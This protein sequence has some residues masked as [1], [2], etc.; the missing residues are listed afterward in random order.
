MDAVPTPSAEPATSA[1]LPATVVTTP[2]GVTRRT[3][4]LDPSATNTFP[5]AST[6]RA[7]ALGM[8]SSAEVPMPLA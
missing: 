1:V 5:L 4:L 3:L 2:A 8:L 7:L 6:A